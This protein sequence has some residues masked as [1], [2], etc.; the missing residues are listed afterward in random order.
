[1]FFGNAYIKE[2]FRKTLRKILKPRAVFHCRSDCT[3]TL[4]LFTHF[5]K[6]FSHYRRKAVRK[7]D[8][9]IARF[10]L[11]GADPVKLSWVSFCRSIAL[12][13]YSIHMNKNRLVYCLCSHKSL[14]KFFKI[15]SVD[16][17]NIVKAKIFKHGAVKYH[18]LDRIFGVTNGIFHRFTY[19]RRLIKH[20]L[21]SALGALI[22]LFCTHGGKI[23]CHSA[24]I[25]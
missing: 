13:F 24:N 6:L 23:F 14:F 5:T 7:Y 25:F 9:G 15:V 3:K 12:A 19:N 20:S 21:Y 2:A 11:K 18:V 22:A 8:V 16:R 4:I 10:Y 1:M 17:S